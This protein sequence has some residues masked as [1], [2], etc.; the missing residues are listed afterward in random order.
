LTAIL[1]GAGLV[2]LAGDL[3]LIVACLETQSALAGTLAAVGIPA[4]V[5]AIVAG[6][7][8]RTGR[9][10]LAIGAFTL[11]LGT[12]LYGLGQAVERLLDAEPDDE[13]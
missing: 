12:V 9:Y 7:S 1:T 11:L 8:D 10:A 2:V 5:L 4:I 6:A 13:P 3:L